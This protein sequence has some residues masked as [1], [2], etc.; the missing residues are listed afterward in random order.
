MFFAL[1]TVEFSRLS[2]NQPSG[3]LF[4]HGDA[5]LLLA[6]GC[7]CASGV[8]RRPRLNAR[9]APSEFSLNA[10]VLG[11]ALADQMLRLYRAKQASINQRRISDLTQA[12][13]PFSVVN[14]GVRVFEQ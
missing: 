14:V 5:Q 13:P 7:R 1:E 3:Q 2:C 8:T 4:Q 9:I 11:D 10:G 12:F 6:S